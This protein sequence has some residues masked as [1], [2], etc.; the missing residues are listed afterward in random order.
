MVDK[1]EYMIFSHLRNDGRQT[2][3]NMSKKTSIPIST[4][5]DKLKLHD[6]D[7]IK[8]HTCLLDFQKLGFTTIA[9]VLINVEKS[10][11]QELRNFLAKHMNVNTVSRV[12]NNFDFLVEVIFKGLGEME[13]FMDNLEETFPIN[14]KQVFYEIEQIK[15]EG[16]MDDP[17]ILDVIV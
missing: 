13:D 17:E 8:K 6:G 14:Q 1:K 3:T 10:Q 7:L 15:K 4:I 2:L 12:N 5:Y 16:F 11:K 9:H